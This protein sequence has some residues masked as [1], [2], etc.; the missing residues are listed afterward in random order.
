M[1]HLRRL[2]A[3]VVLTVLFAVTAFAG[4][5][6]YTISAPP[7]PQQSATAAGEMPYPGAVDLMTVTLS[8]IQSVLALF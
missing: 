4:D 3:V 2:C 8:L 1:R 6:P 5:M 7:L